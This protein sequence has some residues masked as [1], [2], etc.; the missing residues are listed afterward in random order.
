VATSGSLSLSNITF[1]TVG[2]TPAIISRVL[3]IRSS[4]SSVRLTNCDFTRVGRVPGIDRGPVV[5]PDVTL[6]SDRS[7]VDVTFSG[8]VKPLNLAQG[9]FINKSDPIAV[10]IQTVRVPSRCIHFF[11]DGND[12]E[13]H[14]QP[15]APDAERV[16]P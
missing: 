8:A 2:T 5:D 11:R 10:S 6:Y 4:G 16:S 15:W 3:S 1:I 12:I 13:R 14:T 7:N 9:L